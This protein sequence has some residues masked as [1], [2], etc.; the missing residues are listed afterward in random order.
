MMA[1]STTT[2]ELVPPW[3]EWLIRR[4]GTLLA[5]LWGF[6]EGTLFFILPDVLLS[7]TALFRPRR[8]LVH[9]GAIVAGAVLAGTLMFTWS[10]SGASAR[11]AV[12]RVPLVSPAMF[13]RAE[14][15]FR[16]F[17]IWGVSMGP[18][19]GIPTAGFRRWYDSFPTGGCCWARLSFAEQRNAEAECRQ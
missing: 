16:Q 12:A 6:A 13:E 4:P 1:I 14:R 7:F 8:A 18:V 11:H 10:A 15:D 3:A 17:G 2:R 9:M 19:R 5:F